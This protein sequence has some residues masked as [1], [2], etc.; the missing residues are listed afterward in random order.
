MS[1]SFNLRYDDTKSWHFSIVS[2]VK[3]LKWV[4]RT[5]GLLGLERLQQKS[6]FLPLKFMGQI[7]LIFNKIIVCL[8]D[9]IFLQTKSSMRR[10]NSLLF[11]FTK[12]HAIVCFAW[13][14]NKS[15]LLLDIISSILWNIFQ[16]YS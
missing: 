4:Y 6:V 2:N 16:H 3:N 10:G 14:P 9:R 1:P 11:I 5:F 12:I 7:T 13:L 15:H 8:K